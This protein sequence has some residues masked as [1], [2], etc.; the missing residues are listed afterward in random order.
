M[1]KV[2][3]FGN[4]KGAMVNISV[5]QKQADFG[6]NCVISKQQIHKVSTALLTVNSGGTEALSYCGFDLTCFLYECPRIR[7]TLPAFFKADIFD[8]SQQG[9]KRTGGANNTKDGSV[10]VM[11]QCS[12]YS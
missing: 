8:L 7:F 1:Y 12:N 11:F 6:P 9:E 3:A 5:V 2:I 4:K 10:P